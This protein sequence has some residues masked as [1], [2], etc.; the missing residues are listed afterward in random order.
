M[1]GNDYLQ[2]R[3]SFAGQTRHVQL[4]G[5]PTTALANCTNYTRLA[6]QA[7]NQYATHGDA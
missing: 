2:A 5:R 6:M 7:I 1:C 4:L 3:S